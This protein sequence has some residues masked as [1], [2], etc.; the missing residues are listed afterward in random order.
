MMKSRGEKKKKQKKKLKIY[1]DC[2]LTV[3]ERED[4]SRL[5]RGE[6][7]HAVRQ[8]Q[9]ARAAGRSESGGGDGCDGDKKGC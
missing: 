6:R 9:K 1:C 5:A 2:E 7:R 8:C 4:C 3:N